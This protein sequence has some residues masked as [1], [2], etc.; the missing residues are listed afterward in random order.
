M[1]RS[2]SFA[3]ISQLGFY[4]IRASMAQRGPS[5]ELNPAQHTLLPSRPA[6]PVPGQRP[7]LSS[8]FPPPSA[9]F[10]A[11][12]SSLPFSLAGTGTGSA[13]TIVRRGW[14][15]VKEDGLRAWIWGKRWVVLREQT[16][17]FYKNEVSRP[18]EARSSADERSR[19]ATRL[20]RPSFIFANSLPSRERT[21]SRTASPSSLRPRR[22][23]SRSSR[24]RS[25]TP[26]WTTF[27]LARR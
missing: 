15:N 20:P 8:A 26:G 17:N 16:L 2:S 25:S 14:I 3:Y 7:D 18:L 12:P 10:S 1:P 11:S 27:T 23:I 13:Q 21:S 4:P 22:T 6:P 9:N 5:R 24:T 19:R